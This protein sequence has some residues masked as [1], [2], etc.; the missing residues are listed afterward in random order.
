VRDASEVG[1]GIANATVLSG[2]FN[3]FDSNLTAAFQIST[4]WPIMTAISEVW[5]PETWETWDGNL[6]TDGTPQVRRW[7]MNLGLGVGF[8]P[9]E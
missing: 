4:L 2:S 3:F 8:L 1:R 9:F 7:S 5:K 6:G